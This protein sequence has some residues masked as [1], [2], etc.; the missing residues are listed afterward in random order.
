MIP[1]PVA[2]QGTNTADVRRTDAGGN[3]WPMTVC[4]ILAILFPL[5]LLLIIFDRRT[6]VWT[7]RVAWATVL[8]AAM[9]D[10]E[11]ISGKRIR[12]FFMTLLLPMAGGMLLLMAIDARDTILLPLFRYQVLILWAA[13]AWLYCIY[14]ARAIS[15]ATPFAP[16]AWILSLIMGILVLFAAW[17]LLSGILSISPKF[18]FKLLG[19]ELLPYTAFVLLIP[20]FILQASRATIQVSADA[21]WWVIVAAS[22]GFS[23]VLLVNLLGGAPALWQYNHQFFRVDADA[24]M[25]LRL[26]YLFQHHNRA[27][28][29]A[30]AALFLCLAGLVGPLWRHVIA[31]SAAAS[32]A[33]GLPYT[34]TRGALVAAA[35]GAVVLLLGYALA[36][37]AKQAFIALVIAMPIV[38]FFTPTQYRAHIARVFSRQQYQGWQGG[39]INARLIIW[40]STI[41][42]IDKRP[43]LGFGYGFENF[44]TAAQTDHPH[45]AGY[46]EGAVHAHNQWLETAAETG[47]PGAVLLLGFTMMRIGWLGWSWWKVR[48]ANARLASLLLTWLA[49]EVTLQAYGLTNYALRRGLGLMIYSIW[50]GSIALCV[51]A[52]MTD[53]AG[54]VLDV[55][56]VNDSAK[57]STA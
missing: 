57:A 36:R 43:W 45:I 18:S 17:A 50:G 20:R 5:L 9:F 10:R 49:L 24:P 37:R 34:T 56:T 38:W 12:I 53:A 1:P 29:F 39:S 32:A 35:I 47:I 51:R 54:R 3:I 6:E 52:L 28:I 42:M 41:S 31:L 13:V 30:A 48:R 55:R 14:P 25:T 21:C 11:L 7:Q 33:I 40:E 26:Q 19:A 27:G 44:E 46:F 2:V 22:I 23:V 16:A 8:L 15:D 4:R